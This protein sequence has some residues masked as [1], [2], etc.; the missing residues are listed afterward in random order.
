MSSVC[1]MNT[2]SSFSVYGLKVTRSFSATMNR[3]G[4][5]S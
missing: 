4:A 2:K 5:N 3:P 1:L